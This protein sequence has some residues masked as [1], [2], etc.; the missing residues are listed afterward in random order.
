MKAISMRTLRMLI[1]GLAL[2][3]MSQSAFAQTALTPI[4]VAIIGYADATSLPV[5]AQASGI[6][7]KYGLDATV[8]SFNG[9][10]A[11]IAAVAGGSLDMG[12]SNNVSAASAIQ[13]GIPVMVLAP[14]A[15]FDEHAPVDNA[16][17]KARGSKMKGGAD[18]N[19]KTIAVTTLGGGLQLAASAWIDKTGGDSKTVHFVELPNS[20]MGAALKQGRIEAAM[21]SEPAL[22]Q[23]KAS[24]DTELLADAFGAVGPHYTLG[25]FVA[26]KSWVAA[27]PDAAHRFVEAMVETARWANKHHTET[28]KI[29]APLLGVDV[30]TFATTAR[31]TYGDSLTYAMLQP[32]MDVAYKYGQLKTPFD[33]HQM[34]T[35]AQP[36]WRGVR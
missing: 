3:A 31:S 8:T 33:S 28:A 6:F 30:S 14:A 27:N 20:E 11:I 15:V 35:D 7:K 5:Y 1:T 19:G 36:Y 25:V 32:Q 9:G 26:S 29:L 24:G 13:R 2:A 21:L 22:S 23:A 16:L 10:G 12:F 18:L 34:V 17:V 4:R